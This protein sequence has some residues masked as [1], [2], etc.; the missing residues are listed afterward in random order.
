MALAVRIHKDGS[1]DPPD[2]HQ[3]STGWVQKM[4]ALGAIGFDGKV[5]TINSQPPV[6][7]EVVRGPGAYCLYCGDRIGEGPTRNPEVA[8]S[9]IEH[10]KACGVYLGT[11]DHSRGFY[12]VIDYYEGKKH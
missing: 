2:R 4:L 10:V 9:Q 1:V 12:E 3:F 6:E 8:A 11:D 5:I 7:Y